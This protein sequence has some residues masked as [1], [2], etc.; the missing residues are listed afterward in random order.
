[1]IWLS[2][3]SL[4]TQA[5]PQRT[6]TCLDELTKDITKQSGLIWKNKTLKA[7]RS[8]LFDS[9]NHPRTNRKPGQRLSS[10]DVMDGQ[11]WTSLSN[12]SDAPR[13]CP[14][15][16]LSHINI[17]L[18]FILPSHATDSGLKVFEVLVQVRH[19]LDQ[20]SHPQ[21][22]SLAMPVSLLAIAN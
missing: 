16:L 3:M 20:C 14:P 2:P 19:R 17:L 7:S 5:S 11:P 22:P 13:C 9:T 18:G 15:K 12:A 1:M 10:R 4:D 6:A 21:N 8:L